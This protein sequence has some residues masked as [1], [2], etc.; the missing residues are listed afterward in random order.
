MG[1]YTGLRGTVILNDKGVDMASLKFDWSAS[2]VGS[3]KAFSEDG[4]SGFIPFGVH[5]YMPDCWGESFSLVVGNRWEFSCSLKNYEGTIER[6]VSDVLPF[7]ADDWNLEM[8]YE[9]SERS[10]EIKKEQ[11]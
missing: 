8:L 5:S 11:R 2:D 7:I 9:E 4:R 1:M 6:F 3:I 10:T